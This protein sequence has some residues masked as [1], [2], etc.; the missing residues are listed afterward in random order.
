MLSEI[1]VRSGVQDRSQ[2]VLSEVHNKRSALESDPESTPISETALK[3]SL[4]ST[5]GGFPDQGSLTGRQELKLSPKESVTTLQNQ[6]R[7][8]KK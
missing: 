6:C 2:E 3:N 7:I 5:F 8:V 4:G 1:Q